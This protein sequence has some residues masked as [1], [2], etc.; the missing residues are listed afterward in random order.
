MSVVWCPSIN[1]K[2]TPGTWANLK[3]GWTK[4][5][6]YISILS[7]RNIY[8]QVIDPHNEQRVDSNTNSLA[9]LRRQEKYEQRQHYIRETWQDQNHDVVGCLTLEL[10][11][12][13]HGRA[14]VTVVSLFLN[15]CVQVKYK[16]FAPRLELKKK[17]DD[18]HIMR[19]EEKTGWT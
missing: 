8:P 9:S 12:K 16:C 5:T 13:C 14:W 7:W 10:H 3:I 17:T 18:G 1:C 19:T 4:F 6:Y 2:D 11:S 15:S